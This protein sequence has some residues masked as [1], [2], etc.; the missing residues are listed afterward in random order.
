MFFFKQMFVN[1]VIATCRNEEMIELA[2]KAQIRD[3][4]GTGNCQVVACLTFWDLASP[5]LQS[6]YWQISF[7]SG[8]NW[9]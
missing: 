1:T 7:F 3:G 8:K 4:V 5:W 9:R 2:K 6:S